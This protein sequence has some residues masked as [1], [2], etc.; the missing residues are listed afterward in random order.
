MSGVAPPG[1]QPS[2]QP[3]IPSAAVGTPAAILLRRLGTLSALSAT[4][5]DLVRGIAAVPRQHPVRS[6]LCAEGSICLPRFVVSGWACRQRI[7]ADGRRQIVSFLLPGD[8]IGPVLRPRIASPCAAIALTQVETVDGTALGDLSNDPA[9]ARQGIAR[10]VHLIDRLDDVLLRDQIVRLGRQTAYERTLNLLLEFR[11][12]LLAVGL[13]QPDRYAMPLTQETL[14]DALGLSVV[15]VN[16]TLQQI[17]RDGLVELRSG[18]VL[19]KDVELIEATA[20]W[21]PLPRTLD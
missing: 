11:D 7:L 9:A 1:A 6:E 2:A 21:Q 17:R 8:L 20:D 18:M 13:G 16:R 19:L 4:E 10:A 12:R 5:A 15:H 14:A 3:G